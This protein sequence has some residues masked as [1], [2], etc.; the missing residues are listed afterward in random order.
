M[1]FNC[2]SNRFVDKYGSINSQGNSRAFRD[3]SD[4][5]LLCSLEEID[6]DGNVKKADMFYKQTIKAKVSIERV[7]TAVEALNVSINEFG[8]VNLAYMQSIYHPDISDIIK[9]ISEKTENPENEL[10]LS[11][12]L[13]ADFERQKMIKELEGLIFLNP[14]GYNPNNPNAGWEAADE[15]LSGNVRDKL[16]VAKAMMENP[17]QMII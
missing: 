16:R 12:Q 17:V 2:Q 7:E 14:S 5:P 13:K 11:E 1:L 6:E 4:Y 15:Y 8:T 3:D 9:E 10:N